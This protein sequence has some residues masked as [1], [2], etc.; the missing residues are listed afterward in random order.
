MA[1]Y[2]ALVDDTA[3]HHVQSIRQGLDAVAMHLQK[4]QSLGII[5]QFQF[6]VGPDG[7]QAITRFEVLAPIRMTES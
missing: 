4:L 6:G 2:T 1:K 3:A 5:V 7:K